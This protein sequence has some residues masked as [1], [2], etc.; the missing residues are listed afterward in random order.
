MNYITQINIF[1]SIVIDDNR[2]TAFHV[3]MYF[4]LFQLWNKNRFE[5]PLS[6]SRKEVMIMSKIGSTHTYYKILSELHSWGYIE[7]VPE[8]NPLKNSQVF[9][10]VLKNKQSQEVYPNFKRMKSERV[11]KQN[12]LIHTIK[13]SIHKVLKKTT[14]KEPK[15]VVVQKEKIQFKSPTEQD[16]KAFFVK[17]QSNETEAL[18]FFN[19]YTSNG[20]LVGGKSPMHDWQ[21][22][23]RKWISNGNSSNYTIK[24]SISPKQNQNK[25][26][27]EPL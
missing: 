20:W 15:T 11:K 24:P 7:Y 18:N 27:D 13:T 4:G 9:I 1:Y 19:H 5:N 17:A 25:N 8:K 21:A 3:S 12:T 6:I 23:A 26:Y 2:L 10:K 16:L 14:D 22:S